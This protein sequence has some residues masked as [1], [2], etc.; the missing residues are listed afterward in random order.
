MSSDEALLRLLRIAPV[1]ADIHVLTPVAIDPEVRIADSAH[2]VIV[3]MDSSAPCEERPILIREVDPKWMDRFFLWRDPRPPTALQV[4]RHLPQRL[5]YVRK[6]VPSQREAGA[7]IGQRLLH[8][9]CDWGFLL[10]VDGLSYF[11][12]AGWV[13]NPSPCF[14]D[15]PSH[16]QFGFL[17]IVQASG[18]TRQ[19]NETAPFRL[20]AY[21]YWDGNRN[22]LAAQVMAGAPI[23]RVRDFSDVLSRLRSTCLKD[24][25]F[26]ILRAG[27]DEFAHRQREAPGPVRDAVVS[28]VQSDFNALIG[29][30]H[31]RGLRVLAALLSDHGLAWRDEREWRVVERWEHSWHGR[32]SEKPPSV[33]HLATQLGTGA[34]Q[35]Y[36]YHP[37]LLCREPRSNEAAFHGGLS[38][39]ESFVPFIVLEA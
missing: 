36:C 34:L 6:A 22:E 31:D 16:T 17:Q 1:M 24:R 12:C 14:V 13:E 4:D 25:F 21:S 11:D 15:G 2:Q 7:T 3:E 20:H 37:G 29:L 19:L 23:E 27:L 39:S 33:N 28:A 38:A 5:D 32:Y 8:G 30:A 10:L 35:A 18:L 9:Q 26:L